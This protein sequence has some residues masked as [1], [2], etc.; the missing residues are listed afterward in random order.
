[1]KRILA[2]WLV[3]LLVLPLIGCRYTTQPLSERE[4]IVMNHAYTAVPLPVSG[5]D[6]AMGPCVA[7]SREETSIYSQ[8][9]LSTIAADGTYKE[10]VSVPNPSPKHLLRQVFLY[11]S[12]VYA[13]YA[14]GGGKEDSLLLLFRSDGAVLARCTINDGGSTPLFF[15]ANG[16][17]YCILDDAVTVYDET[18]A[19]A[20][21]FLLPFIPYDYRIIAAEDGTE[22]IYLQYDGS[23]WQ[24]DGATGQTTEV[25]EREMYAVPRAY[26]GVGYP[27]Y[28][29][30]ADGIYG[31]DGDE[32]TLL[33]DFA[34]S[35][36]SYLSIKNLYVLSPETFL[37]QYLAAG[38]TEEEYLILQPSAE[39]MER[40][41]FSIAWV[42]TGSASY[43]MF[44]ALVTQYNR[45]G[46]EY[47]ARITD[48]SVYDMTGQ[49]P[50]GLEKFRKDL[51][52]GAQYDLY[53]MDT[54]AAGAL[55]SSM[56]RN[57]SLADLSAL[58]T[59]N[60]LDSV[61]NAYQTQ[62][63]VYFGL[64][65][66]MQYRILASTADTEGT[67]SAMNA[68]TA[69][70]EKEPERATCDLNIR[71]TIATTYALSLIA[72]GTALDSAEYVEVL[73]SAKRFG[74]AAGKVGYEGISTV[75]FDNH[76]E[77]VC[78]G[79]DPT[80]AAQSGEIQY[81]SI[82][83]PHPGYVAAYKLFYGEVP[84][85]YVGYPT[86]NGGAQIQSTV[87]MTFC[88]P[89]DADLYCV[90]DFLSYYLSD[91]VQTGNILENVSFPITSTAL[92]AATSARYYRYWRDPTST[93]THIRFLSSY[94][95]TPPTLPGSD[96]RD[97]HLTDA[98]VEAFRNLI[99]TAV[100]STGRDDMVT[101]IISEELEP[102]FA[103][104][105]SAEDTAEIIQKRA[106]IYL[107]E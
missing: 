8:G 83:I 56:E 49:N 93:N 1:M 102:F 33:C 105:R 16:E 98:E 79:K 94:T 22:Q 52:D 58:Y 74:E 86:T 106:S 59:D 60:I 11:T 7:V 29:V 78:I 107:A 97:V 80:T 27:Y 64:P 84:A 48:Y 14:Y 12:D 20:R 62:N 39:H 72:G 50:P 26:A 103:G 76:L 6:F 34:S 55:Y 18:L 57:G 38:Q 9:Q 42:G 88:A 25:Y 101:Q 69:L 28:L 61:K 68:A 104:D 2:L 4:R 40:I 53:V 92:A 15:A 46:T 24:F 23:V 77:I 45:S 41:P 44:Y 67:L 99:R 66:G 37:V 85:H 32:Q 89:A 96:Y 87:S 54:N 43:E 21:R 63:G 100:L 51:L 75:S 35:F 13:A 91:E 81:L 3:L 47:F 10:T 90:H 82:P 30:L 70:C 31:V 65:Y 19:E 5:I 95:G 17:L 71:E 73:A 36:L